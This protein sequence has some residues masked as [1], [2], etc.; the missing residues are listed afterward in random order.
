MTNTPA[1]SPKVL[2]LIAPQRSRTSAIDLAATSA[3]SARTRKKPLTS[4][5]PARANAPHGDFK[6]HLAEQDRKADDALSLKKAR[7][8]ETEASVADGPSEHS[9]RTA[10][11]PGRGSRVNRGGDTQSRARDDGDDALKKRGVIDSDEG[12]DDRSSERMRGGD[13]ILNGPGVLP[14]CFA[15]VHGMARSDAGTGGGLEPE[16]GDGSARPAVVLAETTPVQLSA[17]GSGVAGDTAAWGS[18]GQSGSAVARVDIAASGLAGD[19]IAVA[20]WSRERARTRAAD[21]L[22]AASDAGTS[23]TTVEANLRGLTLPDQNAATRISASGAGVRTLDAGT[24][25]GP[26]SIALREQTPSSQARGGPQGGPDLPA[27]SGHNGD[28]A[29]PA[30]QAPTEIINTRPIT[31]ASLNELLISVDPVLAE[32]FLRPTS[33]NGPSTADPA[34]SVLSEVAKRGVSEQRTAAKVDGASVSNPAVRD[35][36]L[37]ESNIDVPGLSSSDLR[38]QSNE[39]GEPGS[40]QARGPISGDRATMQAAASTDAADAA[41]ATDAMLRLGLSALSNGGTSAFASSLSALPGVAIAATV[42]GAPSE[43]AQGK[44]FAAPAGTPG[45]DARAESGVETAVAISAASSSENAAGHRNVTSHPP[46]SDTG[47]RHSTD[48]ARQLARGAASLVESALNESAAA[49]GLGRDGRESGVQRDSG[50][51]N[52]LTLRMNPESLGRVRVHLSLD[53]SQVNVRFDV[54]SAE[55]LEAVR[56][57]LAEVRRSLAD[58]GL[59]VDTLSARIDQ[60]LTS[61]STTDSTADT[62]SNVPD[63]QSDSAHA[64]TAQQ[65]SH[66]DEQRGAH[67][68][69]GTVPAPRLARV[70]PGSPTP[71]AFDAPRGQSDHT[72]TIDSHGRLQRHILSTIG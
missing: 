41:N 56:D 60:Q 37:N 51:S 67:R 55:T 50:G 12:T 26:D 46:M 5:E 49:I 2:E 18:A 68:D 23:S 38:V 61:A 11:T 8:R 1:I 63:F 21:A 30:S 28:S 54:S 6:K 16:A 29:T 52:S 58:R 66:G 15:D 39:T 33:L 7:G 36:A 48:L 31:I 10:G 17:E 13:S 40:N 62:R 32:R 47:S 43:Q 65:H 3:A 20:G 44:L 27:Q 71:D 24:S 57:G 35:R 59:Q 69:T 9:G 64:F 25:G 22:Q 14:Q 70:D 34:A 42:L 4:A 53:D 19:G 72:V 45:S